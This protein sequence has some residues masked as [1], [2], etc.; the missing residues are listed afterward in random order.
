[1]QHLHA[2]GRF[3]SQHT[4]RSTI[5]CL[6]SSITLSN[7]QSSVSC[8]GT[9]HLSAHCRI[10]KSLSKAE[11]SMYFAGFCFPNRGRM[12]AKKLEL[13]PTFWPVPS[14]LVSSVGRAL[15]RYRIDHW[16]KCRTGLNFFSFSGFI[17]NT[18]SIVFIDARIS[19]IRWLSSLAGCGKY[20]VVAY[21]FR[22]LLFKLFQFTL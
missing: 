6:Y 4:E 8:N 12:I 10:I 9:L 2:I 20:F 13:D 7:L 16:F 19:Y 5:L 17:S 22:I 14:W 15:R 1:M 21:N 3:S 11:R 18:S